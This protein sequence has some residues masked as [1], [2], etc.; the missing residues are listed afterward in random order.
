MC[1]NRMKWYLHEME[2][3][4]YGIRFCHCWGFWEAQR[5]PVNIAPHQ[6]NHQEGNGS[7]SHYV[8]GPTECLA[9]AYRHH[10]E[11]ALSTYVIQGTHIL[12][13]IEPVEDSPPLANR[14]FQLT[15]AGKICQLV[16]L[17]WLKEAKFCVKISHNFDFWCEASLCAFSFASLSDFKGNLR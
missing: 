13:Q 16:S 15:H 6:A 3:R 17:I 7:T 2:F 1:R 14:D 10:A 11:V 12:A 4:R 5:K 8:S 9:S